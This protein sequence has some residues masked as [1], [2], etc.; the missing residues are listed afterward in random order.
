VPRGTFSLKMPKQN[1]WYWYLGAATRDCLI[2]DCDGN[3][4]QVKAKYANS[5]SSAQEVEIPLIGTP[6]FIY[7]PNG[8]DMHDQ[9][10][11]SLGN[12]EPIP[13]N[14]QLR[15]SIWPI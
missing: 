8:D 13:A 1:Y 15:I 7:E 10:T 14:Y 11:I 4:I 3:A 2:Q 9:I 12:T 5:S 6:Q